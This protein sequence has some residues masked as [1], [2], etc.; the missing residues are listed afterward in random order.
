MP[1]AKKDKKVVYDAKSFIHPVIDSKTGAVSFTDDEGNTVSPS[2]IDI[3]QFS[4]SKPAGIICIFSIVRH[5]GFDH[6][7]ASRTYTTIG[8]D[9]LFTLMGS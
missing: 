9:L 1:K 7:Y 4:F 2:Y 6:P 8:H 5:D 3:Q